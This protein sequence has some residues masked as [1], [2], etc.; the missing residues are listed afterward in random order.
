M[1]NE[2]IKNLVVGVDFSDY[3]KA[4]VNEARE[5]SQKLKCPLT[6]VYSFQMSA[7]ES[8]SKDTRKKF[9]THFEAEVRNWYGLKKTESIFICFGRAYKEIIEFAK[10]LQNPM[11]IA[12][13]R[14]SHSFA[15]FF[16]GSTAER[17]AWFSPFP[18]WIHRGQKVILPRKILIPSDLGSKS[19]RSVLKISSFNKIFKSSLEVYHVFEQPLPVVNF[20]DYANMYDDI[21]KE[22]DE[23]LKVFRKN[24]PRLKVISETGAIV[25]KTNDHAKKFD[26]IAVSP[27]RRKK[28]DSYFGGVTAKLIRSSDR[29]ILV[30]PV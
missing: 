16:V 7:N 19:N 9:A 22:D 29:P 15:R 4:V 8:D 30:I 23:N 2:K 3:S 20:P 10:T 13:H 1:A 17:L 14:G 25:D 6:Y 12:G 11:I 5:L 27:S 28:S 21:K 26:V 18:V 24:H